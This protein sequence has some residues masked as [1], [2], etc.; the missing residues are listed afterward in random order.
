MT[1][2]IYQLRMDLVTHPALKAEYT[3]ANPRLSEIY[4]DV[5]LEAIAILRNAIDGFQDIYFLRKKGIVQRHQWLNWSTSMVN[6][7]RI[8]MTRQLFNL[9]MQRGAFDPEFVEFVAPLF[10]TGELPDPVRTKR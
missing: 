3:K 7:V 5:P 2:K 8:P 10:E 6:V 1:E 4:G 9:G